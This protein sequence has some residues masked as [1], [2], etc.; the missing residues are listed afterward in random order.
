VPAIEPEE[1]LVLTLLREHGVLVHPGYFFDFRR[2]AYLVVSLLPPPAE[3]D[4]A[5]ARI[6]RHVE[7]LSARA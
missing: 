6:V 2:E 1:S 4:E 5:I 7:H 3:F